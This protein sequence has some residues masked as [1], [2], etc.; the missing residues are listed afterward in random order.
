MC[1]RNKATQHNLSVERNASNLLLFDKLKKLTG[2][3]KVMSLLVINFS[4]TAIKCVLSL[5]E[6]KYLLKIFREF[7]FYY[8]QK[9]VILYL[10]LKIL[11]FINSVTMFS[12]V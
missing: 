8:V 11:Q 1:N 5:S 9:R 12:W 3:N 6:R 7:S 10:K 4:E 2:K